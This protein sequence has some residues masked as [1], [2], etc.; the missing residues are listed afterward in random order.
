M[1]SVGLVLGLTVF[2]GCSLI[3]TV[4]TLL[5]FLLYFQIFT[6]YT[7][8]CFMSTPF[9]HFFLFFTFILFLSQLLYTCVFSFFLKKYL[10]IIKNY[11]NRKI[12]KMKKKCSLSLYCVC[13]VAC[14]VW[15]SF[16]KSTKNNLF[17]SFFSFS[18]CLTV[19]VVWYTY[20]QIVQN[21]KIYKIFKI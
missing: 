3:F 6:H 2:V 14:T 20:F 4:Y 1:F 13:L 7:L 16:S 19:R 12:W 5:V 9:M 17:F 18:V 8:L 15:H 21:T 10:E 11:K